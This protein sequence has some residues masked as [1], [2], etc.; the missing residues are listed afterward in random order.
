MKGDYRKCVQG[1]R[2]APSSESLILIYFTPEGKK[3]SSLFC[4]D[5][6]EPRPDFVAHPRFVLH[7]RANVFSKCGWL[8][9][10]LSRVKS[11][12]K[13]PTLSSGDESKGMID[14]CRCEKPIT[15][16]MEV[17]SNICS[18]GRY[19]CLTSGSGSGAIAAR[20]LGW[21]NLNFEFCPHIYNLLNVRLS[22]TNVAR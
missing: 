1:P 9:C 17:L 19:L 16:M 22:R 21:P 5:A 13:G 2:L 18:Q 10:L 6:S 11:F 3:N 7:P 4:Y 8:H 14:V 20:A 12:F 15:L